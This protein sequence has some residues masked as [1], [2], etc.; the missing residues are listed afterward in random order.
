M[1]F[2]RWVVAGCALV[3]GLLPGPA[4]A[5]TSELPVYVS[6]QFKSVAKKASRQLVTSHIVSACPDNKPL[7]KP[8][9]E[10]LAVATEAAIS[11][12]Q[13]GLERALNTFFVKSSV[14]GLVEVVLGDLADTQQSEYPRLAEAL[15]PVS[16]CLVASVIAGREAGQ[17][18]EE[19]RF[20]PDELKALKSEAERLVCRVN[21]RACP[22]VDKVVNLLEQ[23]PVKVDEVVYGLSQIVEGAPFHRKRESLYL[24]SLGDFLARA[25]EHGLYDATWS[26]LTSPD[27]KSRIWDRVGVE[28]RAIAS[29]AFFEYRF[30]N[31]TED[32]MI[33]QLLRDCGL[34]TDAYDGWI[35]A[36]ASLPALRQ[37]LL[38]GSD[39]QEQVEP[40]SALLTYKQCSAG[41]E[42]HQKRLQEMRNQVQSLLVPLE[43]RSAIRRYGVVALSAAALLDY[44]RSSNEEQ[45]SASI[46]RTTVFG[47]AQSV[48]AQ[49][50]TQRLQA[51][52]GRTPAPESRLTGVTMVGPGDVLGTCEFQRV[53]ALLG[54]PYTVADLNAPRCFELNSR[55]TVL[56]I[57]DLVDLGEREDAPIEV[58]A[59]AF[60]QLLK[61]AYFQQNT[62]A[63]G[64]NSELLARLVEESERFLGEV[65]G[66][67]SPTVTQAWPEIRDALVR[68]NASPGDMEA[69]TKLQARAYALAATVPA[70]AS[71]PSLTEERFVQLMLDG[72]SSE[73]EGRL[74]PVWQ[75]WLARKR[76]LEAQQNPSAAEQA[77]L[78]GLR[79]RSQRLPQPREVRAFLEIPKEQRAVE[80]FKLLRGLLRAIAPEI[81]EKIE[82]TLPIGPLAQAAQDGVERRT[83]DSRRRMMRIGADFLVAQADKLAIRIVGADAARCQEDDPKWRSILNR[84]QAACTAHLLIQSAYHPIADYL[85]EGGFTAPGAARLA[86]TSYRQL[87]QSPLLASTPVILNVGLGVNWVRPNKLDSDFVT[88]TVVDKFGLALIK[89]NGP[90]YGFEA[91]PFVGGFLDALVRTASGVEEKYWLAGFTVGFPRMAGLDLGLEAHAAAAMPFTFTPD[92]PQLTLG[93]TVVVPFS[94]VFDSGE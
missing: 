26:F 61:H 16:Q 27:R 50:I 45:L 20:D 10:Q 49:Q 30:L 39:I 6:D 89:Y 77:E 37:S 67:Q 29:G 5:Q 69:R 59:K 93:L 8:I 21:P 3:L 79:S 86:D 53:S 90:S 60:A 14:A 43:F 47:V 22:L 91:G 64:L 83:D 80:V 75:Q 32:D 82:G 28:E 78:A 36:R 41:T 62:P 63:S 94:T 34:P 76:Q 65:M 51:E 85:S 24:Y 23:R 15:E 9:V 57:T 44:V 18:L 35:R 74:A 38:V 19:C 11:K 70:P 13:A 72:V 46:T 71:G 81:L 54:L 66:S 87:L 1:R 88:L 48:A 33:L 56:G 68:L 25:P 2:H 4:R 12:D 58:E 40:L 42:D 7:C 55:T 84:L 52:Q 73:I 17:T 92:K 31:G